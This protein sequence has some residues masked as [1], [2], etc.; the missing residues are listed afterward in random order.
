M[1][2]S[3]L[4]VNAIHCRAHKCQFNSSCDSLYMQVVHLLR[5]PF[6]FLRLLMSPSFHLCPSRW[7]PCRT[8]FVHISVQLLSVLMFLYKGDVCFRHMMWWFGGLR[9]QDAFWNIFFFCLAAFWCGQSL[10]PDR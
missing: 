4:Q 7:L 8:V 9:V 10:T 1:Q 3:T 5:R 6:P 2:C